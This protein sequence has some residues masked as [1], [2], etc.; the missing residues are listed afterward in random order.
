[1]VG[2]QVPSTILPCHPC[3]STAFHSLRCPPGMCSK[4]W[5]SLS[6]C[7][8]LVDCQWRPKR[9]NCIL[10]SVLIAQRKLLCKR[11]PPFLGSVLPVG[12]DYA[13]GF[14]GVGRRQGFSPLEDRAVLWTDLFLWCPWCFPG[15][16]R[17][18]DL[19]AI[20]GNLKS[21]PALHLPS[22]RAV[23]QCWEGNWVRQLFPN[24]VL[25][26]GSL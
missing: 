10:D 9:C 8:P 2:A 13:L 24:A 21:S 3:F 17:L 15:Q 16:R 20:K 19:R 7:F 23:W 25:C 12:Q 1:M 5:Q 11:T 26:L 14:L 18:G 22:R 6:S 4:H